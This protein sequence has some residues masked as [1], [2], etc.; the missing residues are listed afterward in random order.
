MHFHPD[1]VIYV[2]SGTKA[3]FTGKDGTKQTM[4]MNDGMIAVMPSATHSVKN[5]GN[6]TTKV[7]VVEINRPQ[8]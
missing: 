5:V 1:N 2:I 3:E 7:L 8:K 6:K 4:E